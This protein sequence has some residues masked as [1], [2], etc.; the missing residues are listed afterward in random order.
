MTNIKHDPNV[1]PTYAR[2]AVL[3]HMYYNTAT[4]HEFIE[5]LQPIMTITQKE[6]ELAWNLLDYTEDVFGPIED[7]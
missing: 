7:R 3:S 1:D 4:M 2:C 5:N 6:L